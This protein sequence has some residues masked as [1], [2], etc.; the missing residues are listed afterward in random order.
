MSHANLLGNILAKCV[1]ISVKNGVVQQCTQAEPLAL[2]RVFHRTIFSSSQGLSA[3]RLQSKQLLQTQD[4]HVSGFLDKWYNFSEKQRL[5][6]TKAHKGQVTE[7]ILMRPKQWLQGQ[8]QDPWDTLLQ[9]FS[10]GLPRPGFS[11]P[12]SKSRASTSSGV[13]RHPNAPAASLTCLAFFA[14]GIGSA[15]LQMVQLIAICASVL[16]LL[17]EISRMTP[18]K[19][20]ACTP[21]C[22]SHWNGLKQYSKYSTRIFSNY[23]ESTAAWSVR[24][25]CEMVLM[26]GE[27]FCI[28][29]CT[30]ESDPD[31]W[32][33]IQISCW[34]AMCMA[35]LSCL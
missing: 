14:P 26:L 22:L 15:P 19:G 32:W 5:W 17:L 10:T 20:W 1:K 16:P 3:I 23:H 6:L 11:F 29:A 18:S 7:N 21:C 33:L 27:P 35:S 24:S 34:S 4:R 2:R 13:S 28:E 31:I 9:N 12:L 25:Y 8:I 30:I